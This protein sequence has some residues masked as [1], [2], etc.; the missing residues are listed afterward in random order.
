M[1]DATAPRFESPPL[2]TA[3]SLRALFAE[4][5]NFLAQTLAFD[6]PSALAEFIR[7][8]LQA[9][10]DWLLHLDLPEPEGGV[11]SLPHRQIRA[12]REK[13]A[14]QTALMAYLH[15]TAAQNAAL[16]RKMH[17]FTCALLTAPQRDAETLCELIR[18]HFPID[19][20]SLIAWTALDAA[21]QQA[22]SG[23]KE[24]GT[25]LCGRL[26]DAQRRALLGGDFPETGSAAVVAVAGKHDQPL[27][28]LALGR[29]APDG[30]T[31]AHGTL[32]ITQ[33]GELASAFLRSA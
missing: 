24:S 32:F 18:A 29:F 33:I 1:T 23:W 8:A 22:F 14:E 28:L 3:E 20:I 30:F 11:V 16:D 4:Q 12:W 6:T 9:Q 21:A 13:L 5:P 26:S 31:P 7:S 27:S 19:D 17:E 10:P 15:H 25:P 2:P